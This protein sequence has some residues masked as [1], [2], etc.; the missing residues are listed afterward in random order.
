MIGILLFLLRSGLGFLCL[1]WL[2]RRFLVGFR[3]LGC[4]VFGVGLVGLVEF[5][6]SFGL[7]FLFGSL[8]FFLSF[9]YNSLKY[10]SMLIHNSRGNVGAILRRAI[11]EYSLWSAGDY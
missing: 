10:P 8:F 3:L 11:E 6:G 7:G 5:L 2:G 9:Y 1:L 4:L